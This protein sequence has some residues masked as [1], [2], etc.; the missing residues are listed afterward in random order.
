MDLHGA[1]VDGAAVGN[2]KMF[3]SGVGSMLSSSSPGVDIWSIFDLLVS[4]VFSG[5][6]STGVSFFSALVS[7]CYR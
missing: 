4:L 7:D 2:L 6:A 1:I 5:V 3:L